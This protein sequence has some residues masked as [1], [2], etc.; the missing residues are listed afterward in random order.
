MQRGQR[1]IADELIVAAGFDT[2]SIALTSLM[3][4]L[5]NHSNA[6]EMLDRELDNFISE[7]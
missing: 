7:H 3:Y 2:T 1:I 6:I 5:A 4:C